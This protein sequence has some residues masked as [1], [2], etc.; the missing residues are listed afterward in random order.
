MLFEDRDFEK[1]AIKKV[2]RKA[3]LLSGEIKSQS[4]KLSSNPWLLKHREY[5]LCFALPASCKRLL[6]R[7]R[8]PKEASS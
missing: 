1:E 3:R 6:R 7:E 4:A 2:E 5:M 8:Q